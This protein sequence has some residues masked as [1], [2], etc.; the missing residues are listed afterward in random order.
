MG[1]E[2][3]L[4]I[5]RKNEIQATQDIR[6][7]NAIHDEIYKT[8]K[9][10]LI[11]V[12]EAGKVLIRIKESLGHGYFQEWLDKAD[13]NIS[14]STARNYMRV[15]MH[16][17]EI[18]EKMGS[19]AYCMSIE[20]A[21]KCVAGLR[22]EKRQSKTAGSP[23]V[24]NPTFEP[25]SCPHGGEHEYDEEACVKCHDPKPE[26]VGGAAEFEQAVADEEE[27]SA[28]L[29]DEGPGS[30]EAEDSRV[31]QKLFADVERGFIDLY[32]QLTKLTKQYD[33][34]YGTQSLDSLDL[35][36]QDFKKFKK[37]VL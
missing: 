23:V 28:G 15:A 29:V 9:H 1:K 32:R 18:I 30:A 20:A 16:W 35:S 24:L 25:V 3:T 7:A 37:E 5:R 8:S 33:G 10:L 19:R 17:D 4:A 12:V 31:A 6:I 21:L 36:L 13:T 2:L 14:H 34:R 27:S 26:S 11:K 22:E